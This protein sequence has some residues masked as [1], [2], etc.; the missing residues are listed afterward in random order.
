M[1][2]ANI[3]EEENTIVGEIGAIGEV[4]SPI[5]S[6]AKKDNEGSQLGR[7]AGVQS[8]PAQNP[9]ELEIQLRH[10]EI[11]VKM[12][13]PEIDHE[14][15]E[16]EHRFEFEEKRL[17]S[18]REQRIQECQKARQHALVVVVIINAQRRYRVTA[19]NSLPPQSRKWNIVVIVAELVGPFGMWLTWWTFPC[20]V[21]GSTD[22]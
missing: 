22:R 20:R 5:T 15:E 4:F 6:P 12:R 13:C 21:W 16:R 19:T 9:T 1:A 11:E 14:R 3:A 18:E 17:Q 10:L 2:E 7:F 8:T